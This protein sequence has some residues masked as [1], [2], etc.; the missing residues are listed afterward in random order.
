MAP[1]WTPE[2][3][4]SNCRTLLSN[5]LSISFHWVIWKL[6][7]GSCTGLLQQGISKKSNYQ[8]FHL[9]LYHWRNLITKFL[10]MVN[11]EK[12]KKIFWTHWKLIVYGIVFIYQKSYAFSTEK[13]LARTMS[14]SKISQRHKQ[15]LLTRKFWKITEQYI[16]WQF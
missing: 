11:S 3:N 14:F 9:P 13:W 6:G 15:F 1:N 2:H 4:L 7:S 5:I 12:L 16:N 8:A 10:V